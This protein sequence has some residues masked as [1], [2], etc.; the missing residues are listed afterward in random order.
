MTK[1]TSAIFQKSPRRFNPGNPSGRISCIPI[2]IMK[3]IE[4]TL[5]TLGT[6]ARCETALLEGLSNEVKRS[7]N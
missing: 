5:L 7:A 3:R 4:K 6:S 2:K 1:P